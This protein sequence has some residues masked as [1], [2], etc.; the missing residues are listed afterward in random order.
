MNNSRQKAFLTGV[1]GSYSTDHIMG[2]SELGNINAFNGSH[3]SNYVGNYNTSFLG[4]MDGSIH[5]GQPDYSNPNNL[6]HNNVSD[7]VLGE[8]VFENR[9]Y[10]DSAFRDYSCHNDPFRFI[11]KFNGVYPK[12][13]CI[14]VDIDCETYSYTKYCEGDTNVLMD[15]VFKN[16]KAVIINTLFL[17]FAIDYKTNTDGSYEKSEKNFKKLEYKYIV[18]KI[19]ELCNGR[20]FSNNKSLSQESFIMKLDDDSCFNFHR[21][22]PT[23]NHVAYPDSRLKCID[24]LT[25]EICNDKGEKLC[26]KLDGKPH[27]FF[28]EYRRLIDKIIV[29]ENKEKNKDIEHLKPKLHSLK[30]ITSYLSPELHVTFCTIDPQIQT[31]PQYRF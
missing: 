2:Q 17:P 14:H 27:D 30:R 13:E 11:V 6:L 20:S 28:A 8:Q 18:L 12:T 1:N 22:I 29:L 15:R 7:R 9:L 19:N 25:V 10:I 3:D 16:I 4:G 5:L 21:W 31:L 26:P 24:R 23:T